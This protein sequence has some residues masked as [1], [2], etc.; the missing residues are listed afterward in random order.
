MVDSALLWPSFGCES[1]EE[2]RYSPGRQSAGKSRVA[3]KYINYS[4]YFDL[5]HLVH[6]LA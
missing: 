5:S 2:V 4:S 3:E 1:I 6:H